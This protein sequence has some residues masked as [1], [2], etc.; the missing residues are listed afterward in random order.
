MEK[1][2]EEGRLIAHKLRGFSWLKFDFLQ[3]VLLIFG[4]SVF[5]Y[6]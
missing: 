4:K 5:F 6:D 3:D 2:K 1:G